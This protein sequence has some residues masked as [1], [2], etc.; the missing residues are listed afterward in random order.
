MTRKQVK[1]GQKQGVFCGDIK[2]IA[3]VSNGFP[4][5]H[6]LC[7]FHAA[8]CLTALAQRIHS[9]FDLPRL[10]PPCACIQ[11]AEGI[12]FPV[13]VVFMPF[14]DPVHFASAVA[15][16]DERCAS[17][18]TARMLWGVCHFLRDHFTRSMYSAGI[19]C[20]NES[21]AGAGKRGSIPPVLCLRSAGQTYR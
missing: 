19:T 21:I 5:M 11:P 6:F 9:Q 18:V 12:I 7:R 13:L 8:I 10:P 20:C 3:A 15:G 17:W 2:R 4:V 16:T 1:N 14:L